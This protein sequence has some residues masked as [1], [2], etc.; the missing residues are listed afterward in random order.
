MDSPNK[1]VQACEKHFD[2]FIGDCSG[3]VKAVATELGL[4]LD[5]Q[6]NNIVD[7]ILRPPW[8]ELQGNK[9]ANANAALGW[10]VVAG[11]KDMPHGHVVVIVPGSTGDTY[12]TAY[13]GSL[14]GKSGKNK[15]INWAW[16]HVDL[17]NVVF[18]YYTT[19]L[20]G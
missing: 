5:G 17:P 12:P 4:T 11:L 10:F 13:W 6:A 1:I 19:K 3:F 7:E 8:S 20:L 14:A 15:T 2:Q 9:E 16:K 18:G